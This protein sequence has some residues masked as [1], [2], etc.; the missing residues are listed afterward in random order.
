VKILC[1]NFTTTVRQSTLR[2]WSAVTDGIRAHARE[3]NSRELNL[4]RRILYVQNYMLGR[5]WFNAQVFSLPQGCERQIN[6]AVAWFL[7]RGDI[8]GYQCQPSEGGNSRE[9]GT[10][11]MSLRNAAPCCISAYNHKVMTTAHSL[12]LGLGHGT[13]RRRNPIRPRYNGCQ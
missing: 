9:D 12:Q 2:S 10:C 13:S 1:L 7:W 6:T 4:H 5:A 8:F 11:L 3:K